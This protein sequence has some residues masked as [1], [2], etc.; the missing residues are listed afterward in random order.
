M[1]SYTRFIGRRKFSKK[2]KSNSNEWIL[3]Y[4]YC[5]LSISVILHLFEICN[6]FSLR[7]D[8][9]SFK[10]AKFKVKVW[11]LRLHLKFFRQRQQQQQQ[12]RWWT[13]STAPAQPISG[14]SS[15]CHFPS[16]SESC[17]RV[18]VMYKSEKEF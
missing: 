11:H 3:Q 9:K 16:E 12:Q 7:W 2:D 10:T 17:P 13:W 18:V 14:L 6:A 8:R 4:S 1:K 15:R 5:S